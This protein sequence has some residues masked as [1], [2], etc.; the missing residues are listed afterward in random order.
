[1][2][3][4]LRLEHPGAIWHV[5]SRGNERRDI[6][7]ADRDRR[8]FLNILAEVAD[9]HRWIVFAYAIMSNHYHL[10]IETPLPT[11]S[12]GAKRL[13]ERYARWFNVEHRRVGHLFQGRFKSILV[14][15]ESH[16]LELVRYIVLNPVRAGMVEYPGDFEWSSYRA[17]AGLGPAP[18]WLAIDEVLAEFGPGSRAVRC[19]RYR[20][21]VADGRG[22]SYKPWE[23]LVGQIYL[24]GAA[25]CDR[26]QELV[27][28]RCEV[29]VYPSAQR[30]VVRPSFGHVIDV[31][32]ELFALDEAELRRRSHHAA[33][34]A[35][36]SLAS[37]EA[38]IPCTVAGEWMGISGPAVSKLAIKAIVLEATDW[39][40]AERI[41]EA[42]RRLGMPE[43]EELTGP[44]VSEG[45]TD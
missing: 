16:L 30:K 35:L 8:Q 41:E 19:E 13:N 27:G 25:F 32:S 44:L 7:R 17:T 5:T 42:R 6:V 9:R 36:A 20:E 23:Q 3:R 40:F 38:G 26:V 34:K 12:V 2:A 1:M 14:E 10:L 33:R 21:F 31:V 28:A 11:L 22:A 4:A 39:V 37:R 45:T 24:G 43:V 18:S 15:R 29:L